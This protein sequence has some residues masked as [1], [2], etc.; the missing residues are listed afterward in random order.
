[1]DTRDKIAADLRAVTESQPGVEALL[2]S[3]R[4]RIVVLMTIDFRAEDFDE[5]E[6]ARAVERM[7]AARHAA[8][9]VAHTIK[10]LERLVL[11]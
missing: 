1:M 3:A 9:T 7:H 4:R 5:E 8:V 2:D 10:R 6:F 11:M